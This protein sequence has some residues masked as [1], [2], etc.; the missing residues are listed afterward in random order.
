MI[1][2][3]TTQD[4]DEL[5]S[6]LYKATMEIYPDYAVHDMEI[7]RKTII[8]HLA[9]PTE[10]V[11]V[12]DNLNGFVVIKD[13]VESVTPNYHRYFILRIYIEPEKRHTRLYKEIYDEVFNRYPE[14]EIWGITEINSP[15]IKILDKRHEVVA[16]IYKAR[17]D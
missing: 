11:L 14:G 10:L 12:D 9:E 13:L 6:M 7:Y 16:K 2:E 4:L 17:R 3:A 5:T 15:H 8:D 1:R